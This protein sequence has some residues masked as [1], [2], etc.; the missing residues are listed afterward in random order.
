MAGKKKKKK[1][2]ATEGTTATAPMGKADTDLVQEAYEEVLKK[3]TG[4]FLD[5]VHREEAE[6]NFVSGLS[7]LRDA[8]DRAI[9][10]L[11]GNSASPPN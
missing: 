10:L 7:M 11:Q 6:T 9:Q 5:A 1:K 3:R 8:R 2:A 4:I